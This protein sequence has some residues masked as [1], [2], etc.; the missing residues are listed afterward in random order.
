MFTMLY[1]ILYKMYCVMYKLRRDVLQVVHRYIYIVQL[2]V[3]KVN[4]HTDQIDVQQF[5]HFA[6]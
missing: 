2:V 4:I 5:V 1:M 6:Y 3:Q